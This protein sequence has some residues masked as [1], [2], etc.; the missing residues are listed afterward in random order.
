MK[1][2]GRK[3]LHA[4]RLFL[5]L[6]FALYPAATA[7][8]GGS[9][10]LAGLSA[11]LSGGVCGVRGASLSATEKPDEKN[12]H[13]YTGR[14]DEDDAEAKEHHCNLLRQPIILRS[15]EKICLLNQPLEGYDKREDL[16]VESHD[17]DDCVHCIV[18]HDR[19]RTVYFGHAPTSRTAMIRS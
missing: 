6:G 7:I 11:V 13:E 5:F 8:F 16:L 3:N 19:S 17:C 18:S 9:S 4:C 10:G 14:W 2:A 15:L 12:W 1:G